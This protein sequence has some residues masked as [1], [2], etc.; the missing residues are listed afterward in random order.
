MKNT[1][2]FSITHKASRRSFLQSAGTMA[3]GASFLPWLA[4]SS[5]AENLL[6]DNKPLGIALVGLGYYS[7]YQLAPALK[8]TKFC[9]LTGIVTGTPSKAT[10][11]EKKYTIPKKNI[12]DYKT[13]DRIADNKDIDIVYIVLPNSM[14]AEYTI[15]ALQAGK[16]VICEKPMAVSVKECQQMIDAAKKANRQLSIGYRLHY[17]PHHQEVMKYGRE[18]TFGKV[19]IVETSDGF[20]IG[21]PNQWRLKKALAGGGAM[22]DIGIY[23]LQGSRY[24]V[25]E[26]PVS[27]WA[28]EFKTDSVKF[29][30]VDETILWQLKFPGGA[31]ANSSCSYA[32]GL[33]RLFATCED[34]WFEMGPCYGYG[35]IKGRTS[36]GDMNLPQLNHQAAQMDDFAQCILTNKPTRTPGEEGLKDMRVIEAI[37]RSIETGKVVPVS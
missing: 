14:H 37:Y 2:I 9:K 32:A 30:E 29:K 20:K 13:I 6:Q 19:K 17:T 28:Q 16:H 12:Y 23:A 11:W 27:V 33:E 22:M 1:E 21:D 3:L 5:Q 26:E 25:G 15:R 36:K 35:A 24:T 4:E 31:V 18:K 7:A 34:G 10:E 8:Q